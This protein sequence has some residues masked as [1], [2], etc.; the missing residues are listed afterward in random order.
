[1]LSTRKAIF[2]LRFR[3][4]RLRA[5]YTLIEL[6]IA[7]GIIAVVYGLIL[8]CYIQSG[9][10]AQWSGYSLAAQSLGISQIEQ[11]RQASW[12]AIGGSGGH[13]NLTNFVK[14]GFL[15]ISNNTANQTWTGYTTNILDIPY[16]TT[17]YVIATNYVSSQILNLNNDANQAQI[18]LFRVDTVWP[19]NYRSTNATY[20]TNTIMTY[21]APDNE[22]PTNLCPTTSP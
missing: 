21:L 9:L 4:S 12:D 7:T 17:N 22:S 18:C 13:N 16:A 5:G 3:S 8:N 10:M 20:F 2:R 14:F 1:M 6:V 15:G 19:F 11:A